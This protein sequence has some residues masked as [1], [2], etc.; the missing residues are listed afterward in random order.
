MVVAFVIVIVIQA[1][2]RKRQQG[3]Q[4]PFLNN[5][6]N[7]I[8]PNNPNFN[9]SNDVIII[10]SN[11]PQNPTYQPPT[12]VN[13]QL[14]QQ[15]PNLPYQQGINNQGYIQQQSQGTYVNPQ[16]VGGLNQGHVE[17]HYRYE[18]ENR[19]INERIG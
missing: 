7:P 11:N 19:V 13:P 17:R 14:N 12:N 10:S 6:Y 16:Q 3:I 5:N 9:T 1:L 4:V 2:R 15:N 18:Q 8:N